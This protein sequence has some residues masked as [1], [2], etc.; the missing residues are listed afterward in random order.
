M[1]TEYGRKGPPPATNPGKT[2]RLLDDIALAAAKIYY[3]TAAG[4][5]QRLRPSTVER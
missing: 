3:L 4:S 1:T 2:N 5:E